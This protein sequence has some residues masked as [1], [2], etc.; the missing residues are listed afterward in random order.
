MI[1][2]LCSLILYSQSTLSDCSL[3]NKVNAIIKFE[4]GGKSSVS[5][6]WS[7]PWASV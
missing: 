1:H 2:S 6:L 7:K 3:K 4:W 5:L